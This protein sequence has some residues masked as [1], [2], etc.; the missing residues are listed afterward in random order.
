MDVAPS[1][2]SDVFRAVDRLTVGE[3]A[4][5]AGCL[6]RPDDPR[7]SVPAEALL[8]ASM[9]AA[10]SARFARRFQDFEP[11]AA[12][13]IWIKWYINVI[14]PPALL[15]DLF[16]QLRLPLSLAHTGFIIG[17][18]ARVAAVKIGGSPDDVAGADPFDRFRP[19]DLRSLRAA[20][21][22]VERAK[23]HHAPR[24]VEQRGKHLRSD[25]GQGRSRL[26]PDRAP[27]RRTVAD[28]P[29]T[30]EGR[31][32][33]PA[34]RRRSLREP[35]RRKHPAQARLLSSVPSSRPTVLQSLSGRGGAGADLR[36]SVGVRRPRML[37]HWRTQELQTWKSHRSTASAP[38]GSGGSRF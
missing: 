15:C 16:L 22:I 38:A 6:A 31:P 33:K 11:R 17:D 18:D 37:Y 24:A 25:A 34:P 12:L 28:R 35:R 27:R 14:L 9:K 29:A 23:R 7:P 30:M 10:I 32:A 36:R 20:D 5:F 21:R 13:S 26:R 3:Y 8:D 2:P 4:S 1:L 19:P